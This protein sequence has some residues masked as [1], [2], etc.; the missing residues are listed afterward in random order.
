MVGRNET[1]SSVSKGHNKG[2]VVQNVC[3]SFELN[4]QDVLYISKLMVNFVS[5]TKVISTKGDQLS[6]K[7]QIIT[8]QIGHDD[9]FNN[10]F[11]MV[12]I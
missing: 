11:K 8:L 7:G 12:L 3:S 4:L 2:L 9:L 5:S 1:M 10:I 6:S